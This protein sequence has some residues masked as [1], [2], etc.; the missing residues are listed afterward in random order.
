MSESQSAKYSVK[1][2]SDVRADKKNLQICRNYK[3]GIPWLR[4]T[5]AAAVRAQRPKPFCC[6]E[7]VRRN[8]DGRRTGT[9]I[10]VASRPES[11]AS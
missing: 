9:G 11:M 5:C 4:R 6:I 1:K 7:L 3:R 2:R 10:A 8:V